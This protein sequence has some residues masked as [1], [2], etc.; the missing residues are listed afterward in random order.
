MN[1]HDD[2]LLEAVIDALEA[3]AVEPDPTKRLLILRR[4]RSTL[5][6]WKEE[7]VTTEEA[8]STLLGV[9]PVEAREHAPPPPPAR[10]DRP[11][12]KRG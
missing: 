10:S 8:I 5:E 12:R 2:A 4:T 11:G 9:R 7:R 1:G 3:E 6:A